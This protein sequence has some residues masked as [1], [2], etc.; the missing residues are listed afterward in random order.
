MPA[1]TKTQTELRRSPLR[2]PGAA[3]HTSG[4]RRAARAGA[5]TLATL[6]AARTATVQRAFPTRRWRGHP[7][8]PARARDCAARRRSPGLAVSE[9]LTTSQTERP[10]G[11]AITRRAGCGTWRSACGP[12]RSAEPHDSDYATAER[13]SC[14]A[15]TNLKMGTCRDEAIKAACRRYGQR[16]AWRCVCVCVG[17]GGGSQP[18]RPSPGESAGPAKQGR[19][20]RGGGVSGYGAEPA[21]ASRRAAARSRNSAARNQPRAPSPANAAFPV[22]AETLRQAPPARPPRARPPFL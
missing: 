7:T 15:R 19:R 14:T 6:L 4:R 16:R 8:P 9:T 21:A 18:A 22:K 1:P 12:H 3:A 13:Y 17:G 5:H 10:G 20:G 2:V 11:R